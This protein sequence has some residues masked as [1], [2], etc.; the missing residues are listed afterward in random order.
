MGM[1]KDIFNKYICNTRCKCNLLKAYI[2]AQ[3]TTTTA[4]T[5]TGTAVKAV[6][7]ACR[8]YMLYEQ[9]QRLQKLRQR[10]RG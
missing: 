4:G 5:T 10:R 9:A 1:S 2:T 8:A 3:T 6:D 7:V